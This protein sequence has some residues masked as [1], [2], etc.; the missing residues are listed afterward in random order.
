VRGAKLTLSNLQLAPAEKRSKFPV[1]T[2]LST[3]WSMYKGQ[4]YGIT[5][6]TSGTSVLSQTL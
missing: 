1:K 3:C 6:K 2:H 5:T 4:T